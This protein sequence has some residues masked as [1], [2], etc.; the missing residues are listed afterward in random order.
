MQTVRQHKKAEKAAKEE[1]TKQELDA[2]WRQ[3]SGGGRAFKLPL[4][5]D[6]DT[7]MRIVQ[8]VEHKHQTVGQVVKEAIAILYGREIPGATLRSSG[9]IFNARG[10][11][12]CAHNAR[13]RAAMS[14]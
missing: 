11:K 10:H 6:E 2:G 5:H 13:I 9:Y 4:L 7:G 1:I 3:V 8:L 12:Q 14:V